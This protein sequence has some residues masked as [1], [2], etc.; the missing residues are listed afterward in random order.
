MIKLGVWG[1]KSVDSKFTLNTNKPF[2]FTQTL[3][4]HTGVTKKLTTPL[5][6]FRI[7]PVLPDNDIK[8]GT[9]VEL[10]FKEAF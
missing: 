4:N 7:L 6:P 10:N 2:H 3:S 8:C 9:R 1:G 5:L